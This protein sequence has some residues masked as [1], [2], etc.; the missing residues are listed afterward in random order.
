MLPA[1]RIDTPRLLLRSWQAEDAD[2]LRDVFAASRPALERWTPWVLYGSETIDA[3]REKLQG[4]AD[5]FSAGVEWRYAMI[6][7]DDERIVGGASLHPRVGAAAIEIGYWLATSATGQ[8]FA[9]EA[10]EALTAE[11]FRARDIDRIEI[12]CEPANEASMRVP[13]RLG[14][15]ARPDVVH[16]PATPGR[17][18]G[19]VVVW[20]RVAESPRDPAR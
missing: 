4:Y 12:R 11:A 14:Y 17:P 6:A 2:E 9:T 10:A 18:G 16:E 5:N 7:R 19:D 20:E 13:E 8:G 3:L 15:R 1:T